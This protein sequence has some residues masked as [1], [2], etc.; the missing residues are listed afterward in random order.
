MLKPYIKPHLSLEDQLAK[1]KSRG[2]KVADEGTALK[3]LHW[4]GYYRLSAYWYPFRVWVPALDGNGKQLFDKHGNPEYKRGDQFHA[5]STFEN[6]CDLY[7]FDK[8]LKLLLLDAIEKIEIAVRADIGLKLGAI[9]T[10]AHLEPAFF[11]PNFTTRRNAQGRTKYDGWLEKFHHS[12]DRSKDEFVYHHQRKHGVKSPLPIWIATEL[13]DFGQLSTFYSGLNTPHRVTIASTFGIRDWSVMES[14]LK[15]LNYIRNIIAH[16]GRLWNKAL[17]IQPGLPAPGLISDFDILLQN[18][19]INT[20]IYF[21]CCILS[22][23]SRMM[24]S[25]SMWPRQLRNLI[26]EFPPMSHASIQNM[27]FPL[28]WQSHGFWN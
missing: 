13:W 2:L 18:S 3:Y 12:I 6:A 15:S 4:N 16:H 24:N 26:N 22:H 17:V 28:D 11:T 19:T 8:K 10:F 21:I 25:Q 5:G 9:N 23:F 14:W 1:L 20:R 7:R 27:G